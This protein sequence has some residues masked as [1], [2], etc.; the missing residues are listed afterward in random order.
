M[1]GLR[2]LLVAAGA[3][4]FVLQTGSAPARAQGTKIITFDAPGADT[5]PGDFYGTFPEGINVWGTIM[6]YYL[7]ANGTYHAFVRHANGKFTTFDAPGADTK[8]GDFNGTVPN[9]A[10]VSPKSLPQ[11][12][13]G[14]FNAKSGFM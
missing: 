5:T 12:S 11:S 7:D 8:P 3:L 10:T 6:G 4:A 9:A 13:T 14:R 2:T 1:F